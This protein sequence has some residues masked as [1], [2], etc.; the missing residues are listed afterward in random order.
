MAVKIPIY[1]S[2]T[3]PQGEI[4]TRAQGMEVAS[5]GAGQERIGA[6]LQNLGNAGEKLGGVMMHI[7]NE[8]AA[9]LK[10]KEDD[11]AIAAVSKGLSDITLQSDAMLKDAATDEHP[12]GLAGRQLQQYDEL[13]QTFLSGVNNPAARKVAETHL[14]SLRNSVGSRAISLEAQGAM[15]QRSA[16]LSTAND[17][18][19]KR[20]FDDPSL[21]DETRKAWDLAVA[22]SG[23]DYAN[24]A[25]L[26]IQGR[27]NI[28][29]AAM[30]STIQKNPQAAQQALSHMTY[31]GFDSAVQFTLQHEGGLNPSDTNGTPSKFGIN[32]A[33]NPGVDLSTLT[34]E[35]ARDI[36][37]KK[38]WD[39]IG[40]DALAAKNPVLAT[41]AFDTAVIAGPARAKAMLEASG[42][43]PAQ[44]IAER[45][46]FLQGLVKKDPE[47]YGKYAKAWNQRNQDLSNM[48]Q[49]GAA[50]ETGLVQEIARGLDPD[51]LHPFLSA[52]QTEVNRAQATYRA[53]LVQTE[54]DHMAAFANGE[55]VPQPLTAAQFVNAYGTDEGAQRFENY[56]RAQVMAGDIASLKLMPPEQQT[57]LLERNKPDPAKPGYALDAKRY[58][59][60]VNAAN[61]VNE[62]RSKDPMQ[63]AIQN[64]IG[65]AQA[66][67]F[68]SL[69]TLGTQLANRAAVAKTMQ[70][71]YRV[72]G[73][74]LTNAEASTLS[75]GFGAMTTEQKK[76]YL[77]TMQRSVTDPAAYRSLLQ[78]IAP[79]S[80]VTAKAGALMQKQAFSVPRWF[81][82]DENY[83][84][85]DVAGI[86]LE[87]EALLNPSKASKK[88]DGVGK[89][90]PMPSDDKLRP[91]FAA[92]VGKAYAGLPAIA[93]ADYQAV[94]AYYAGRMA[95][96]GDISGD[97]NS[98][99]LQEAITAVTGGVSDINGKGE[100]LR[101]WGMGE[102]QFEDAAKA[103][104][105][106]EIKRMGLTGSNADNWGVY[107][108]QSAGDGRYLV[109]SGAGY[110][111]DPTTRKPVVLTIGQPQGD[112]GW[113]PNPGDLRPDGTQKGRGWLGVLQRPDGGVSTEISISTNAIG[114]KD[115]PL[116]VPT[117]TR[118]E[119]DKILAIPTDD[120]KFFDKVPK[121]AISKAEAFA[122][123]R[124]RD[125][126]SPFADDQESLQPPAVV[127]Q[128]KVTRYGV[129]G[130]GL[131]K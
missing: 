73:V 118:D 129:N 42:G 69:D 119:I 55:S 111:I 22:N 83:I 58:D 70:G 45:Q 127:T 87:G 71:T 56:H 109:K 84:P 74:L 100:V 93:D 96:L 91:D 52:A 38:Y 40:G 21:I 66:I 105:D 95:R 17:N 113:Q 28:A 20:V 64:G 103:A 12:D 86:M 51:Q 27:Q 126:K 97:V 128:P 104:F 47:K 72:P 5:P 117:L 61:T 32:A 125:G 81:K 90:F 49:Y 102:T 25:K 50:P 26:A 80:P 123:Q 115:F 43:D 116:L 13:M 29:K 60:L 106:A 57:Q 68:N 7:S 41:M 130:K 34:R 35:G 31:G 63:Y 10:K 88:Q 30:L 76:S 85:G 89:Q 65:G 101:P 14:Y 112:A 67:D 46:T 79:D 120:P 82:S 53:G 110:M 98:R 108:L 99:V 8:Q 39:A 4:R 11:D 15:A 122:E 62:A 16:N 124:V 19:A 36:Y 33:N 114:G 107:G 78:Q 75:A 18:Y 54:D 44:F 2:Q 37:R 59:I 1:E 121:T 6:A 92:R 9:L 131:K 48:I 77:T 24:R 3:L 23:L 94:R